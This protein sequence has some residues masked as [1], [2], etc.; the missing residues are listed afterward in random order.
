MGTAAAVAVVAAAVAV[1]VVA[2]VEA[3]VAAI[4]AAVAAAAVVAAAARA[5][6]V[7][8]VAKAIE[9][10]AVAIARTAAVVVAKATARA[11][12]AVVA[13]H[14]VQG[15]RLRS[16]P[17]PHHFHMPARLKEREVSM[18]RNRKHRVAA[19]AAVEP[20][21]AT[22]GAPAVAPAAAVKALVFP[23][24]SGNR[25]EKLRLNVSSP[26]LTVTVVTTFL[27]NGKH[28]CQKYTGSASGLLIPT[29]I[30]DT[31]HQ[32]AHHHL[33]LSLEA[34]TATAAAV[35]AAAGEAI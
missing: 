33:P 22:A 9:A 21:V 35:T 7:A 20:A 30:Q 25:T 24:A 12:A 29:G 8:E 26:S 14:L 1:I 27:M 31:G 13:K 32:A 34:A 15:R 6:A 11:A 19:V 4:V 10:A 5:K 3:A 18:S 2:V 16:S 17:R 28:T 23:I